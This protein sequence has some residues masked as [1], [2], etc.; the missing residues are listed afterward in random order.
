MS[1][2]QS[3]IKRIGMA[4]ALGA[5]VPAAHLPGQAREWDPPAEDQVELTLHVNTGIY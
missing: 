2:I 4:V 3:R 1:S 5:L